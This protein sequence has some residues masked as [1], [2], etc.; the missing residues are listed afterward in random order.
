M[1]SWMMNPPV[2]TSHILS[3]ASEVHWDGEIWS[4]SDGDQ[5]HR[6]TYAAAALRVRR[7][8]GALFALG[9][10]QGD[11]VTVF[12]WNNFRLFELAYALSGIGA[13]FHPINPR[14]PIG[15]VRY[16]LEQVRSRVVFF[17]RSLSALVEDLRV[18]FDEKCLF[19]VNSDRTAIEGM[20][21]RIMVY[22]DLVESGELLQHWPEFGDDTAATLCYTSGSTGVPKGVLYS[23]RSI[24]W[25]SLVNIA[26]RLHA[27]GPDKHVMP[28]VCFFHANAWGL[29][30]SLPLSG[31]SMVLPDNNL[32]G[33]SVYKLMEQAGVHSAH[34]VPT[35]CQGLLNHMREHAGCKPREL[36]LLCV[37]GS[38]VSREFIEDF[39]TRFGI[40]VEHGWGMTEL[41]PSGTA[42]FREGDT[43]N[44]D[45]EALLSKKLMQGQRYFGV[46]M[47][48]LN[49]SGARQ[50]H[51][52]QISGALYVR[53]P[54]VTRAYFNNEEANADLLDS[55]GWLNTGDI[56]R[57]HP[58]GGLEIV[59]RK[60]D[61]IKSGGEWIS[62]A[63]IE[64]IVRKHP[65]VVQCAVTGIPDER[66]GE[67]PIL[68]VQCRPGAMAP[69]GEVL[70]MI[71]VHLPKW[72]RPDRVVYLDQLPLNANGK[73]DKMYLKRL[74][75]DRQESV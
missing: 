61:L 52:G 18:S 40:A 42:G 11:V 39:E 4:S 66:W 48:I 75:S 34:G 35:V 2:L 60:K 46:E 51:D 27:F 71:G 20:T 54:S 9:V 41:G 29:P 33:R 1:Q 7:L 47:K 72:H 14:M 74:Y 13:V 21:A 12:G 68:F 49:E 44:L 57:I 59:D 50:P 64:K 25:H 73:V 10:H 65:G 15:S 19:V 53:G 5:A 24:I 31:S 32:D 62:P 3:Y 56:A 43:G 23:H 55:D 70:D 67:R 8:A 26:G 63:T 30:F 36:Q 69:E 16:I 45:R 6:Y 22:E 17:D 28:L 38:G 58:D 37:G